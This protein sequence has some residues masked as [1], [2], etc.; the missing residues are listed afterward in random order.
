M[1]V[2]MQFRQQGYKILSFAQAHWFVGASG[3][4]PSEHQLHSLCASDAS[5]GDRC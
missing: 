2:I 3:A 5:M 4:R 1:Q